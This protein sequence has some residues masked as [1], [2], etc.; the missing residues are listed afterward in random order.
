MTTSISPGTL[1][2]GT[3]SDGAVQ[4]IGAALDPAV[5]ADG[6]AFRLQTAAAS[7]ARA[8]DWQARAAEAYRA[9]MDAWLVDLA[10]LR[11]DLDAILG[12]LRA[13]YSRLSA[14]SGRADG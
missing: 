9:A 8:T 12:D 13:E 4:A 2:F 6:Q 1:L 14:L 10:L 3:F 5:R 11:I 7:I